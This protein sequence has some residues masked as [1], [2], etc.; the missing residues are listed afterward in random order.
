MGGLVAISGLLPF[1]SGKTF[2]TLALVS[3]LRRL[4][5]S[6]AVAKPVS[7]HSIWDQYEY[8]VESRRLGLLVGED[9]V[10]YMRAG[11]I[12][13]VDV[14]NPID[15]LTAPHDVMKHPSL[16]SYYASLS[17]VI[18]QAVLVRVSASDRRDYYVVEEN[19][20]RLSEHLESEVRELISRIRAGVKVDRAWLYSKLTSRE[21]DTAVTESIGKL[22]RGHDL[23]FCESFS[24]ALLPTF[25]LKNLVT[26]IVVVAPSRALAYGVTKTAAYMS[27]LNHLR[28]EASTL[29]ALLKP[30]LVLKVKPGL[31]PEAIIDEEEGNKLLDLLSTLSK[32]S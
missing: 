23:V 8:F 14:Q 6:V 2:F 31:T 24:N 10:K 7:A 15:V 3:Y 29:V 17:S 18:D 4:G 13:D 9:V 16:D 30:D 5:Y 26:H 25:G 27:G 19:V 1:N 22:T 28:M 12:S 20:G 21:V 32:R 11:F